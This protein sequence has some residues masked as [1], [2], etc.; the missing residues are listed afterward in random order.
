MSYIHFLQLIKENKSLYEQEET[1]N[2][3]QEEA[4]FGNKVW[5]TCYF[6]KKGKEKWR[7][8][9]WYGKNERSKK[10]VKDSDD[11]KNNDDNKDGNKD[12]NDNDSKDDDKDDDKDDKGWQGQWRRRH[13]KKEKR[14]TTTTTTD[15]NDDDDND[16][17][18]IFEF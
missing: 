18:L 6:Q 11:D 5:Q 1:V 7:Q 17:H 8:G 2:Y 12:G 14:K 15:D 3:D 13:R 10:Q 16:N 9:L 4:V